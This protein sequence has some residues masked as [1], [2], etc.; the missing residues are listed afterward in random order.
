MSTQ[1][2][3]LDRLAEVQSRIRRAARDAGRNPAEVG[4]VCVSKTIGADRIQPL[5]TAGCR[6]F[7]ENRVQEAAEKW[8]ALRAAFPDLILR[9]IGPLQTNKV[10]DAVRLFDV[11]ESLDRP[12][13]A[14]EIA[15]QAVREGKRPRLLVQVNI[16]EEPQKAGVM[17]AD[18]DGFIRHCRDDLGLSIEGLMCI[19]PVDHLASPYFAQLAAIAAR[20]GLKHLSMGMTSDFEQAIKLGATEVRVGSAIFG[21]R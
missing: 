15:A 19:P 7:G 13:L 18:A 6:Q 9:L 14:A 1:E 20:N 16:G 11:I 2:T 8:P 4:L 5:L 10:R 12:K 17:P 3:D 21:A